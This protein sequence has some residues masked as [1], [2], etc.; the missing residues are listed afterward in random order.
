MPAFG[1]ACFPQRRKPQAN[2]PARPSA[3][4]GRNYATLKNGVT[5][6]RPEVFI[7]YVRENYDDVEFLSIGVLQT[8]PRLR[9]IQGAVDHFPRTTP[10]EAGQEFGQIID[11]G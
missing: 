7:S 3:G 2:R 8:S 4:L 6:R 11:I 10:V 5:M 1:L 9:K